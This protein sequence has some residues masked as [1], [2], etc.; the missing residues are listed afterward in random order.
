MTFN[1]DKMREKTELNQDVST[2]NRL[3]LQKA[4]GY[5]FKDDQLLIESLLHRSCGLDGMALFKR[6]AATSNERLEF[7]GDA[8]LSLALS[9]VLVEHPAGY[10]EGDL[11]QMRAALVNE[12]AL[13]EIAK[14]I[15]L[16][17]CLLLSQ[18]E[19][20]SG[21]RGKSS[22]LADA[23]EALLGAVFKEAGFEVAKAV[24]LRLYDSILAN[25][26][27]SLLKKDHKT[28][29]QELIQQRFKDRPIYKVVSQCGPEHEKQ[30]AVQ[31]SYRS[32]ILGEGV[33]NTKKQASQ[34]AAESALFSLESDPGILAADSV[35][36]ASVLPVC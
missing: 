13:A 16:D 24:V 36:T 28:R 34:R 5:R 18:S 15:G 4:I 23:L 9:Q 21:G 11:S 7:L 12:D 8:V 1:E 27:K 31:V 10:D 2:L 6:E 3:E 26:L 33:G 22:L 25:S 20:K 14:K 30:F 29:L 32:R 17:R 35:V 19:E